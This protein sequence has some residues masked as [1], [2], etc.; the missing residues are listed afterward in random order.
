MKRQ[1]PEEA[2][3]THDQDIS[4]ETQGE[5]PPADDT[6]DGWA[7]QLHLTDKGRIAAVAANVFDVL[8][9]DPL[10]HGVIA[11][12]EHAQ[13]V[14]K[15]KSPPYATGK[16]GEWCDQDDTQTAMWLTRRYDFAP[17]ST[18]VLEAVEALAKIYTF[19][20]VQDW[21]NALPAW[22]SEKR[23]GN[24]LVK[25]LGVEANSPRQAAYVRRAGA[26]F[27]MG[28]VARAMRPGCQFDY[29]LVLEG[30]QGK[31]KS[32][33]LRALIPDQWFGD[34]DLDLNNKDAMVALQGKLLYEIAEMGAIARSE[35]KR[36][37]SFLTRRFDEFRPH[38]GR[39]NISLPRRCVF[40]GSTNEWEWNK[41]PTGGR[42]FWPVMV[43]TIDV[44][45]LIADRDLLFAEAL[46]YWREGVRYW[47][48]EKEQRTLF[49]TEQLSR[50]VTDSYVDGLQEWVDN[51]YI[52]FSMFTA[53]ADGLGLAPCKMTRDVQIRVGT[54]LRKLGCQK[55]E[56]RHGTTRFWYVP[57]MCG[58]DQVKA[59]TESPLS[60]DTENPD[61]VEQEGGDHVPF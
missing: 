19:N 53:M 35:E 52:P 26:W 43:G 60:T 31:R 50:E 40:A 25:Y 23:I 6:K 55:V 42:R 14:V 56:K 32:T 33:A 34:T 27:I 49:D 47:P 16:I 61:Q 21:L 37:K 2:P 57:P 58:S 1:A 18:R 20:P 51:Q 54:A 9:N 3:A 45:A 13:R 29:C 30:D 22:D 15:R 39:R 24:W 11:Y 41:D 10:W 7:A 38:Y 17:T 4:A 12:D 59:T 8:A 28:I 5:P 44:E 48:T 46:H 36:Q